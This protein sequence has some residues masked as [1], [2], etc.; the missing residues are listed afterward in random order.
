MR[1]NWKMPLLTTITA[2]VEAA[3]RTGLAFVYDCA[4]QPTKQGRIDN[5]QESERYLQ[6]PDFFRDSVNS[7]HFAAPTAYFP[8]ILTG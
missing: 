7:C 3:T 4:N 8:P 5:G 1:F 2:T 6:P